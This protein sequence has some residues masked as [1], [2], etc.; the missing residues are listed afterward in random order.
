MHLHQHVEAAVAPVEHDAG[1]GDA[2]DRHVGFAEHFVG[3]EVGEIGRVL[4][5]VVER[6]LA[7]AEQFLVGHEPV[8]LGDEAR[9]LLQRAEAAVA[10]QVDSH[11]LEHVRAHGD[12][13]A[14]V[15]AIV[16][17]QR[18]QFAAAHLNVEG[19]DG[20]VGGEQRVSG[21]ALLVLGRL[22]GHFRFFG[23][24]VLAR[25]H[26]A[27]RDDDGEEQNGGK[28]PPIHFNFTSRSE[29][30]SNQ[31]SPEMARNSQTSVTSSLG[32]ATSNS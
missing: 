18:G 25:R 1:M 4:A 13:A 32:G 12:G 24:V 17:L 10:L 19:V 8:E 26:P 28:A 14:H 15:A 11:I 22:A 7:L 9:L 20:R 3:H 29:P 16:L 5:G 6:E 31:T 21:S 23:R 30:V 27:H 2:G